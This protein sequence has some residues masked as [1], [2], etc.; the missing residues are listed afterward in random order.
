MIAERLAEEIPRT[1]HVS[2]MCARCGGRFETTERSV[3]R[4]TRL[5]PE[6]RYPNKEATPTPQD[7]LWVA[8]LDEPTRE[9]ALAG[10]EALR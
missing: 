5:C 10:L 8:A 9:T 6:C 7:R 2:V 1:A 4:G 3:L